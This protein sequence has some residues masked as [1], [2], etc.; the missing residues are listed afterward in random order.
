MR[1]TSATFSVS[2]SDKAVEPGG[3]EVV[4][5]L[6]PES[7]GTR[8]PMSGGSPANALPVRQVRANSA[9]NGSKNEDPAHHSRGTEG[10][11]T[12]PGAR[13]LGTRRTRGSRSPRRAGSDDDND[14]DDEESDRS[15]R[16]VR[17][18]STCDAVAVRF[19]SR[20]SKQA[21]EAADQ[22]RERVLG[23][24]AEPREGKPTASRDCSASGRGLRPRESEVPNRAS[25]YSRPPKSPRTD[26]VTP[27]GGGRLVE[28]SSDCTAILDGPASH[29]G[30]TTTVRGKDDPIYGTVRE[31][32][33]VFERTTTPSPSASGRNA[34][35]EA[36][37]IT[38]TTVTVT[39]F[40][41]RM[42]ALEAQFEADM[43]N[44]GVPTT[45]AGGGATSLSSFGQVSAPG[46]VPRRTS[47]VTPVPTAPVSDTAGALAN[48]RG[49]AQEALQ[50]AGRAYSDLQIRASLAQE[51][52]GQRLRYES[53]LAEALQNR[54][55]SEEV[56]ARTWEHS[57]NESVAEGRA[58]RV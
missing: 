16:P 22:M 4:I 34:P 45:D 33:A 24:Q 49:E 42:A 2:S 55:N 1:K 39:S 58:M 30:T 20:G 5:V 46:P 53:E 14:D 11:A 8:P 56:L 19:S 44:A 6:Q 32:A 38:K 31:R 17:G 40:S 23:E 15:H 3:P 12:T 26:C 21:R 52:V 51:D 18:S 36:R 27:S 47:G 29:P 57:F 25:P 7:Q 48:M 13:K 37:E 43:T 35:A 9:P 54:Y 50:H 28:D 41:D 10:R